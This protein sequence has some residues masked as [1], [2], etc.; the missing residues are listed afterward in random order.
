MSIE[1][2]NIE[3]LPVTILLP[4]DYRLSCDQQMAREAYGTVWNAP[5]LCEERFPISGSGVVNCP[6]KLAVVN[7]Q[8]E[9]P[10]VLE[11]IRTQRG[12]LP[13]AEHPFTFGR[14]RRDSTFQDN[15]GRHISYYLSYSVIGL[16][17]PASGGAPE[18]IVVDYDQLKW[19]ATDRPWSRGCAFIM[20]VQ[21][22]SQTIDV[23]VQ[24]DEFH[25]RESLAEL[26][27]SQLS[28]RRQN[29]KW[30][31]VTVERWIDVTGGIDHRIP[32]MGSV[33]SSDKDKLWLRVT[34]T[35]S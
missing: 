25:D 35:E 5:E 24:K 4:V 26:V 29:V 12:T 16:V 2:P 23:Q 17:V 28:L 18:G 6:C 13:K 22:I 7:Y 32:C 20:I 33:R 27:A 15:H 34:Y 19:T 14:L 30:P 21:N 9:T 11:F 1:K 10:E 3:V 8:V 31:R